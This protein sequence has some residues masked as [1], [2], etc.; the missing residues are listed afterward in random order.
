M[1]S[2]K[3]K[4]ILVPLDG[5]DNSL[6]GLKFAMQLSKQADLSIVGLNVYSLPKYLK[7]S[8][9]IRN[10]FRQISSDIINQ[11]EIITRKNGIKFTGVSMAKENIGKTVVDFAYKQH[12]D[13][14]VIGSRGVDSEI[15]MFLGSTANYVMN[16]SKTPVVIIK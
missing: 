15:E 3:F 10:K 2:T 1:K 11:A 4:K 8:W 16:K 7:S 14:I 6:R 9:N 12:V 5:S 13:L